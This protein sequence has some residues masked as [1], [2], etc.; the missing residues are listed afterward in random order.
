VF[1]RRGDAGLVVVEVMDTGIG[2]PPNDQKQIFDR[3]YRADRSGTSAESESGAGIGLSIVHNIL[4]LHGCTIHVESEPG[5]GSTFRFTLPMAEAPDGEDS[6]GKPGDS[7]FQ[8]TGEP[9]PPEDH[10]PNGRPRLRIIR[11]RT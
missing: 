7:R 5:E 1:T 6:Q 4:R 11:K 2:I 9:E 10:E 8:R 3:F